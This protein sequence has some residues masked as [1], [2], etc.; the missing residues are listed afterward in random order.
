MIVGVCFSGVAGVGGACKRVMNIQ[1][2]YESAK[3]SFNQLSDLGRESK[4][5]LARNHLTADDKQQ[6]LNDISHKL[7]LIEDSALPIPDVK[8]FI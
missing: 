2:K 3:T 8:H 6:L 7:S 1:Q 5:I 4:V